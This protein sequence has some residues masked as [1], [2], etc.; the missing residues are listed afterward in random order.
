MCIIIDL[1]WTGKM[2]VLIGPMT[3]VASRLNGYLGELCSDL[4]A[5]VVADTVL[6][7]SRFLNTPGVVVTLAESAEMMCNGQRFSS[8]KGLA[9]YLHY[10][11]LTALTDI[12]QLIREA[13][14]C[15]VARGRILNEV[16]YRITTPSGCF[17]LCRATKYVDAV[18][19]CWA[20]KTA[21]FG[22]HVDPLAVLAANGLLPSAYS[23]YINVNAI[24]HAAMPDWL[25]CELTTMFFGQKN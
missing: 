9:K 20:G 16:A 6:V 11:R 19:I 24:Q 17:I 2:T 10:G 25:L 3:T 15:V 23:G 1:V 7:G 13:S 12:V 14:P 8:A 5:V 22:E 18:V 21:A 4:R